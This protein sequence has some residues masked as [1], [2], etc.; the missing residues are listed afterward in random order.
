MSVIFIIFIIIFIIIS[1]CVGVFCQSFINLFAKPKP[2]DLLKNALL[3]Y[4]LMKCGKVD[5]L[6]SFNYKKFDGSV[7][8]AFSGCSTSNAC[9][10]YI[11][12]F[13]HCFFDKLS[14]SVMRD[15]KEAIDKYI[16][17]NLDTNEK[18]IDFF[19]Q[20]TEKYS[21]ESEDES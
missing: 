13:Y 5:R 17:K 21:H 10:S 9:F 6:P 12:S 1:I 4:A 7:L 14:S 8:P 15:K 3:S 11:Q 2:Q 18:V 19:E 16:D 20:F